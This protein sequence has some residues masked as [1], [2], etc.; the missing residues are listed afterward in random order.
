LHEYKKKDI[1]NAFVVTGFP[2]IG[3][4]GTIA[5]RFII[6]ALS[7]ETIGALFSDYF[8]PVAVISKGTPLPPV[9]IYAGN[10]KCGPNGECEQIIVITSEFMPPP[11]MI[12]PLANKII[13][14]CKQKNCELIVAIEGFNT[15]EEKKIPLYGITSSHKKKSLMKKYNVEL[16]KEGMVSGVSG[17]LLYEGKKKAFDVICLLAGT[18][19]EYPDAKAAAKILEIVNKMLPEIEIDPEPLYKEA[20]EIEQQL[21]KFLREAQPQDQMMPKPEGGMYR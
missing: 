6:N 15:E 13:D 1:S 11:S 16:M 5:S 7:L 8:H 4:V 10:K 3:V 18:H 19:M 2:T 9:R 14:W 21:K 12:R 17:V 20:E